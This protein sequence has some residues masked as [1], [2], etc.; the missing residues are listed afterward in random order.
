MPFDAGLP[1]AAW[2]ALARAVPQPPLEDD[3]QGRL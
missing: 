3:A 1:F 2:L